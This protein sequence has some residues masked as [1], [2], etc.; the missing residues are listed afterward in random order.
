MNPSRLYGI[1]DTPGEKFR[2]RREAVRRGRASEVR[3]HLIGRGPGW[4]R[5]CPVLTALL[6][7]TPSPRER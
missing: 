7:S 1:L 2:N 5:A 3:I 6:S 4:H